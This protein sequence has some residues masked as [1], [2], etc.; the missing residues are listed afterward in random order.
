MYKSVTKNKFLKNDQDD[1]CEC[2]KGFYISY[3]NNY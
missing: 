1:S 2:T 3:L